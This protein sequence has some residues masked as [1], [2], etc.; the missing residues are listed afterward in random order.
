MLD[1]MRRWSAGRGR[2]VRRWQP[3]RPRWVQQPVFRRDRL[4]LLAVTCVLASCRTCSFGCVAGFDAVMVGMGNAWPLERGRGGGAGRWAARGLRTRSGLRTR[5]KRK[6]PRPRCARKRKCAP[7][8]RTR[9]GAAWRPRSLCRRCRALADET[10]LASTLPG[11]VCSVSSMGTENWGLGPSPLMHLDLAAGGDAQGTHGCAE[12][13]PS[14]RPH[15]LRNSLGVHRR[16]R[17]RVQ[18]RLRGV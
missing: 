4:D 14:G 7:R 12:N 15:C 13:R 10:L 3:G 6:R 2:G 16:L 8:S 18:A 1:E 5:R 17:R 9:Q 11:L